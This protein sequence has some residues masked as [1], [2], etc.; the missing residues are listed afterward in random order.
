MKKLLLSS[1]LLL[2]IQ[3]AGFGQSTFGL[4]LDSWFP[5]GDLKEDSPELWGAGFSMEALA[6]LN[7]SPVHV[8]GQLGWLRY[9]SEVR[10]GWHGPGLGD[11]RLRRHNEM[12]N[13]M[14]IIRLKPDVYGSIQPY[15]DFTAGF[16]YVYTRALYRDSGIRDPFREDTE[17][18]D[19][20][21]NY[22]L[23]GGLEIFLS[24]EVS[25][26]IRMRT[27][28]GSRTDY[29]TARSVEYNTETDLYDMEIK[30]SNLDFM[31][32]SIGIKAVLW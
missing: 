12:A 15:V 17:L 9:G 29:L 1:L 28:K 19:F 21:F 11:I 7:N 27:L 32:F 26:D 23:G 4:H 8:G 10:D 14:G 16:S 5:T 2:S 18:R 22:G 31:T 6:Q 3:F 24:D 30:Q 20:A 13:L 25:L